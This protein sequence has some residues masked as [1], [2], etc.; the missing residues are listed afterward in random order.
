MHVLQAVQDI[1]TCVANGIVEVFGVNRDEIYIV[2]DR[3]HPDHLFV[4]GQLWSQ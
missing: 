1:I 2:V 3:V 4:R